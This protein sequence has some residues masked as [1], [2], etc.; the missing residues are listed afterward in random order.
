MRQ[1]TPGFTHTLG[2]RLLQQW[3]ASRALPPPYWGP[4]QSLGVKVTVDMLERRAIENKRFIQGIGQ[5]FGKHLLVQGWSVCIGYFGNSAD[6]TT[7]SA[8]PGY[9]NL[10]SRYSFVW[11]SNSHLNFSPGWE[12][13]QVMAA[14]TLETD[15]K[16]A[17]TARVISPSRTSSHLW[18]LTPRRRLNYD[19]TG[20]PL[21]YRKLLKDT[22]C[23]NQEDG[24]A[25][26]YRECRLRLKYYALRSKLQLALE[27]KV[28]WIS[29]ARFFFGRVKLE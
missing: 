14:S 1:D 15:E 19:G 6:I 7:D 23:V 9:L 22:F 17:A 2:L 21:V 20:Q 13:Y 28:F 3:S 12:F 26:R 29:R 25:Y 11:C 4:K 27:W 5:S 18:A 10:L 8:K 16:M 24:C